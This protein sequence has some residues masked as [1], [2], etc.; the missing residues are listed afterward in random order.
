ML[1]NPGDISTL[2]EKIYSDRGWDFRDYKKTSLSRRIFK[3]LAAHRVSSYRDYCDVL[4]SD[5]A[6]YSTLFSN[7]TIKVSEFFREKEVFE[8]LCETVKSSFAPGE[9]IKAWCCACAHGEEAYSLAILLE[10]CLTP[11]ALR[12]MK[13][14]ATDIDHEALDQARKAAYWEDSL[15]NVS[16]EMRERYFFRADGMYKVKYNIRNLVKFGVLDIVRSPSI[17]GVNILFCRNLFIYFNKPLQESVFEK[18]DYSLRPG[19]ILVL[20]KAEVLPSSFASRYAPIGKT[21]IFRKIRK[22]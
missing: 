16:P 14:F 13:L 6:E 20:G 22:P 11:E 1:Q 19:G 2:L 9:H 12:H 10:R 7:I 3:R 21:N 4:E 5:P 8:T 15:R 18:L 17:S